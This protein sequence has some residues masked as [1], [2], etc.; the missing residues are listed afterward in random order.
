MKSPLELVFKRVEGLDVAMDVYIPDSA[1]KE[2][3]VP[4]FLWWHGVPP[5]MLKAPD[6]HNLCLI[7]ADYRL[8]PQT[9]LPGIL[10][11]CKSAIDFL[12]ASEFA[13]A[14]ENCVDVSRV[15]LSGSSAGG[16]LCLLAGTGIGF[17][18]CGLERPRPVRGIVALYPITDLQDPF[19]KTKQHPVS[20][21]DHI[22][23]R[24]EVEPFV[25]P[26]DVKTTW[27]A[28]EDRR[29]IFYDY[30]VQE[31]IL[32][33]LLL[34][35]TGIPERS[36]SIADSLRSKKFKLPPTYIMT[37]N[38]D[39]KVPHVQSTNVFEAAKAIGASIEYHELEG[40]D[41]AFDFDPNVHYEDT[42]AFSPSTMSPALYS[43]TSNGIHV[44]GVH[45]NGI[46]TNGTH[47]L[48][49]RIDGF[50]TRAVHVGS[51]PNEETGAVI[52]AISL[53]TTYKQQAIGVHK[54]FEYS[55]SG[56]PNRNAL[57]DTLA[58]L[59]GGGAYALAFASGSSTTAT[60]LQSLGPNAHIVSVNDVY[61]GTFRYIRRVAAENQGLEATFLDLENASDEDIIASFRENTKLVW[62]ES[63]TNPTLR[64]IDIQRIAHLAHSHPF[65]P[66]VL[67]DN[68]FLS[69]FYSSPLLLGADIVLHSLTKYI[70]GHSDVVMGALILPDSQAVLADKLRFLQNAIGAVPS[71]YD[72]WLAQRGAKTLHL[73][74][75]Q[76]GLNALAVARAL[77]TSPGVEEVIYPGLPGKTEV[78]R[79]RNKL[80]WRVLSPAARK[81]IGA[82][83]DHPPANGFPFSGMISFR[84]RGGQEEADRFLT[85]TRLFT[86]AESLGGVESLAEHPAQMTHG[87]IPPAERAIL[88][89]GDN[90]IRLSV[91]VEE[92][93]DLVDDVLQAVRAAT[94]L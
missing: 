65:R 32:S 51:E 20:Y 93:E 11:D 34:D 68:T 46:H 2:A 4:V 57:E 52:P 60:V 71:A 30:M 73:R 21:R 10:S 7:S 59:E 72:C 13:E 31:A 50:G 70:N 75:K 58:A 27:C 89:I 28:F 85:S 40:L 6:K 81:F 54:G 36:F 94:G 76:H 29:W 5:H 74:M 67:V 43:A 77:E 90:L 87:S 64:L 86:L 16:W 83:G 17:E 47:P 35:G 39:K 22:I 53:S 33:E 9:R 3:P 23:D 15:V 62:I 42:I 84:I 88:G 49:K 8:A 26:D 14:T 61:G 44:N 45:T 55:R 1:S 48:K 92:E 91:G 56:N 24:A 18:A 19:W 78:S 66:V 12:H 79:R 38:N 25:N 37:G 69:P 41:H 63:P 80:A 82:E